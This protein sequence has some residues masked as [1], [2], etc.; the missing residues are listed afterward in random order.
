V[1]PLLFADHGLSAAEISSLFALWS[2][3]AFALE[4]PSGAWADMVSRRRLLALGQVLRA[5]G[6]AMWVAVPSYPAFAAGF[7]L[8]GAGGALTSG[9]EQALVYDELAALGHAADYPGV[10]GRAG[11]ARLLGN[12]AA[13]LAATPLV[14]LGGYRLAGAVSVVA[15][16]AAAGVALSFPEAPRVEDAGEG[17]YL[18]TLRAGLREAAGYRV[19]RNAVLLA[20]LL[21]GLW[22]I[23]EYLPLLAGADG[24]SVA[25]VQAVATAL[26]GR[27]ARKRPAAVAGLVGG[28][29][30]LL[31]AGAL[32][33]HPAGFALVAL[34]MGALSLGDVLVDARLQESIEGSARATVTSV[35]GFGAEVTAV[36]LYGAYGLG[37]AGGLDVA[38]LVAAFAVPLALVALVTPRW[39]PRVS[40][41]SV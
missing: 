40:P 30:A 8:W 41:T 3:T 4:V 21:S 23:D 15:C 32:V 20:A 14:V 12:A 34:A 22:A 19:V 10:M 36:M 24:A 25:E 9:T 37:A 18:A 27:C 29:A 28:G 38:T 17:R 7:V 1:Y 13:V 31:A 33:R 39:L 2:V 6:F 11:T 5:L 26:A 16:L 35:A